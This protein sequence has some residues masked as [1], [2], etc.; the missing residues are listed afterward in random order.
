[1]VKG[2][3]RNGVTRF[4][5][6]RIYFLQRLLLRMGT[7]VEAK[8]QNIIYSYIENATFPVNYATG[9]IVIVIL[10]RCN[11]YNILQMNKSQKE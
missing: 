4:K 6:Q 5:V 11:R 9:I 3:S 1:M 2:Y 10:I 7:S 8:W